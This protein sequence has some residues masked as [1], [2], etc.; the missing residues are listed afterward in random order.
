MPSCARPPSAQPQSDDRGRAKWRGD[1]CPHPE[2]P[3][4][5]GPAEAKPRRSRQA[6]A[7]PTKRCRGPGLAPSGQ[8]AAAVPQFHDGPA[9][10]P[11]GTRTRTRSPRATARCP[12]VPGTDRTR[13]GTGRVAGA[14]K[15]E[16]SRL[17]RV[18]GDGRRGDPSVRVRRRRRG[19]G[20]GRR[21]HDNRRRRRFGAGAGA[22]TAAH[23]DRPGPGRRIRLAAAG[24]EPGLHPPA[25]GPARPVP[26]R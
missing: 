6:D 17:R 8:P 24:R 10:A 3:G 23:H 9:R 4:A 21:D 18:G 15:A 13:R 2:R 19:R 5:A 12:E 14:R 11:Q 22:P 16:S 25:G 20:R 7:D 1:R 26:R